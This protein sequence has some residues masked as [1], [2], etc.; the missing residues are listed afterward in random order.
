MRQT[1]LPAASSGKPTQATITPSLPAPPPARLSPELEEALVAARRHTAGLTVPDHLQRPHP[2]VA[3]WIS[4]TPDQARGRKTLARRRSVAGR[5]HGHRAAP[6]PHSEHSIH[7]RREAWLHRKVDDRGRTFLEIDGEPAVLTLKEKF[8]Q[9]RRPLTEEEKRQGFDPKGLGNPRRRRLAF[10]S[11]ASRPFSMPHFPILDRR[12]RA[13]ARTPSS[14]KSQQCSLRRRRSCRCGGG[15]IPG[16]RKAPP[17][18]EI[19]CYEQRRKNAHRDRNRLRGLLEF[20]GRAKEVQTAREFLDG[21]RR[22]PATSRPSSSA[23]GSLDD[24]IAWARDRLAARAPLQT[25]AETVFNT[26][27]SID[28]WTHERI[29]ART[30]ISSH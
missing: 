9:V 27:A 30:E 17:R 23:A 6:A 20:A 19:R 11:L 16:S 10:C 15:A 28:Q 25:G 5:F 24:W 7:R 1:P 13:T 8:R 3:G 22:K 18:G 12:P 21:S 29:G 14:R 26:V 2:I 4:G